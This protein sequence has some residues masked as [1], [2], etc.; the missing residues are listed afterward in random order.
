MNPLARTLV[1][2]MLKAR[3]KRKTEAAKNVARQA[4]REGAT[5]GAQTSVRR[6]HNMSVRKFTVTKDKQTGKEIKTEVDPKTGKPIN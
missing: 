3:K 2:G 6:V 1:T 4:L 5:E